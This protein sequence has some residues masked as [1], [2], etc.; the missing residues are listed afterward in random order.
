MKKINKC[1]AIADAVIKTNNN[2]INL[3]KNIQL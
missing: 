1:L 2:V 3:Y